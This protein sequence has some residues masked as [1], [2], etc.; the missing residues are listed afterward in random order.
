MGVQLFFY[1]FIDFPAF[2]GLLQCKLAV[3]AAPGF[4][5]FPFGL[6]GLDVRLDSVNSVCQRR[7]R[8]LAFPDGDDIPAYGFETLVVE[9]VAILIA[10]DFIFPELYVSLRDGIF[11][12][13]RMSVPEASIHENGCT[14]HWKH[15]VRCAGKC[16]YAFAEAISAMPQLTPCRLFWTRVL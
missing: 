14:I 7:A 2:A 6:V 10:G 5:Y 4:E 13:A 1:Q 11:G 15:D 12:A 9:C 8:Q 3:M 16:A